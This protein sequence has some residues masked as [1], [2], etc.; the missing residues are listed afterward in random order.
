VRIARSPLSKAGLDIHKPFLYA[1]AKNQERAVENTSV[2]DN[3][4]YSQT[5]WRTRVLLDVEMCKT[6]IP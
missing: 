4:E 1:S 5:A 2:A 3:L 6:V